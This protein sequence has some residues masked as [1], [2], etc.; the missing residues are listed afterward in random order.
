MAFPQPG[1]PAPAFT[2]KDQNGQTVKLQDFKGTKLVLYF[3]PKDDTPGC[4]AQACSLRDNYRA[5]QKAGYQIIGIS[6]DDEKR[7]TR[8]RQKYN[9]PFTLL[10]DT[11]KKVHEA[12]GTW[13]KKSMYGREYMGTARVTFLINA[14]GLIEE[15]IEKVNTKE[16]A[17]QIMGEAPAT[18]PAAK[19][20]KKAAVKKAAAKKAVAKKK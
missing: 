19:A 12:Y 7:H 9:L 8:F 17:A 13:I 1:T 20:P 11:D 16:H 2:A 6:T 15:V 10:A 5:L 4:T 14:K 18:K 3:Y